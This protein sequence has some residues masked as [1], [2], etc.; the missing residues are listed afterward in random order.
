MEKPTKVEVGQ[1]WNLKERPEWGTF[2][3]IEQQSHDRWGGRWTGIKPTET[4]IWAT[5]SILASMTFLGWAP[6]YGPQPP[7]YPTPWEFCTRA[8]CPS[9]MAPHEHRQLNPDT[10]ESRITTAWQPFVASRPSK[11]PAPKPAVDNPPPMATTAL[12]AIRS[13]KPPEPWRPSI[14]DWDLLPDA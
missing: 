8:G 12:E 10:F 1:Q 11:R 6:G 7:A 14:D 5:V 13:R 2:T 9:F 3:V 4:L